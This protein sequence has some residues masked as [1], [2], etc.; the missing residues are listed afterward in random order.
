MAVNAKAYIQW[1]I[2]VLLMLFIRNFLQFLHIVNQLFH[3]CCKHPALDDA[4]AI[5]QVPRN[6][7]AVIVCFIHQI[8]LFKD[9][10]EQILILVPHS[11]SMFVH[12][13]FRLVQMWF[14]WQYDASWHWTRYG[15]WNI[16]YFT[17][18]LARINYH[19]G[20]WL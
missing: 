15:Y 3:F 12:Y 17:L 7:V 20:Y 1:E 14:C 6:F 19:I 5:K 13:M 2:R 10:D 18:S 11:K 9:V 16:L 4:N 8:M